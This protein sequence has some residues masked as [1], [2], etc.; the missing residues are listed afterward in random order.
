MGTCMQYLV[1]M[2]LNV[3][4]TL[5]IANLV[6]N[7]PSK[8]RD[9]TIASFKKDISVN[10]PYAKLFINVLN[11]IL[12]TLTVDGQAPSGTLLWQHLGPVYGQDYYLILFATDIQHGMPSVGLFNSQY[13]PRAIDS[14]VDLV[15]G[16]LDRRNTWE[17]L[18]NFPRKTHRC[19]VLDEATLKLSCQSLRWQTPMY[20]NIDCKIK[21]SCKSIDILNLPTFAFW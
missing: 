8:F 1:D 16:C 20:W 21:R 12:N 13:Q 2:Y 3:T 4:L 6:Q 19:M 10:K 18:V 9:E 7:Y 14:H 5:W 17:I 11:F 15:A